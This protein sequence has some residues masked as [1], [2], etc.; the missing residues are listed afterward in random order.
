MRV[1]R[2]AVVLERDGWLSV[3]IGDLPFRRGERVEVV[4][5]E[6]IADSAAPGPLDYRVSPLAPP[7]V[8]DRGEWVLLGVILL[9][10]GLFCV[11]WPRL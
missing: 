7:P 4:V 3:T 8:G 6:P 1:H 9:I 5:I 2:T 11:F 10:A